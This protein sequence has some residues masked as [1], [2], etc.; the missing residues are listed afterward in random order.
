M[1]KILFVIASLFV[2]GSIQSASA[3]GDYNDVPP[4]DPQFKQCLA[5]SKKNYEGGDEKSPI[6]GQ[7]KAVAFCECMWNETPDDFKGNLAKFSES[8]AGKKTNKTCEKYSN[9][10]E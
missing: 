7:S 2:I 9:W 3:A 8:A 5:Y 1:N 10:G 6:P 4:N